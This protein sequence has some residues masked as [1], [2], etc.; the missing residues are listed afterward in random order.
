MHM[1]DIHVSFCHLCSSSLSPAHPHW[2]GSLLGLQRKEPST[3]TQ[4]FFFHPQTLHN[5][6]LQAHF[7]SLCA[8]CWLPPASVHHLQS[9]IG[10]FFY[11]IIL[12]N[13]HQ[14]LCAWTL[15]SLS[16]QGV[17]T[18][19]FGCYSQVVDVPYVLLVTPGGH[20]SHVTYGALQH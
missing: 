1:L 5:L 14:G 4:G 12:D 8:A 19:Y 20:E 9:Y 10:V 3:H 16:T 17:F 15:L 2:P 18:R 6:V 13:P 11:I 7:Y